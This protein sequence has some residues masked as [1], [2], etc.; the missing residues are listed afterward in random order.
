[1]DDGMGGQA[2]TGQ[3]PGGVGLAG[4]RQVPGIVKAR[5]GVM[6]ESF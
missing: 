3:E 5:S 2:R 6:G 4:A 1:M